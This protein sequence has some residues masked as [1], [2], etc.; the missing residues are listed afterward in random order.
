MKFQ[1]LLST[2]N[3]IKESSSLIEKSLE[4]SYKVRAK[5]MENYE[6]N[7]DICQRSAQFY[8][9]IS[10]IYELNIVTFTHKFLEVMNVQKVSDFLESIGIQ[11]IKK[12]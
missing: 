7:K 4:E 10:K 3:N 5:L 11:N 8:M 1:K 2:L 12:N 6:Q 9:G